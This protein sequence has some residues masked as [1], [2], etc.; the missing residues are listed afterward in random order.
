MG[1]EQVERWLAPGGVLAR[2]LPGYAPRPAQEAMARRVAEAL[3]RGGVLVCEA[4]TGTGKTLAYLLPA[5]LSGRRVV[6][7]TG[8]RTLQDQ[9]FHRELPLLRRVLAA[10]GLPLRAA[11]LKGRANYLCLHRLAL[12][13]EG[14]WASRREAG[15]WRKVRAWSRRTRTGDVAELEGIPEDAAL[16]PRVTS[17]ADNCLGQACP[18]L[19]DCFLM[20]ARQRAQEASLVVVNHHLLLAGL[21][22][23]E[24]GHGE[25]LPE[26]EA[27]VVDEAHHLPE[28][29]LRF[30]DEGLTA[31][32][33]LELARDA[34]AE[35]RR[36]AGDQEHLEAAARRLEASVAAL[37][38]A[39][40][41]PGRRE[42]WE[43][44]GPVPLRALEAVG[45][46]LEELAGELEAA[47]PRG[48]GLAHCLRR[49][50]ELLE[51]LRRLGA[52]EEGRVRWFETTA[53]GFGLHRTPLEPAEALERWRRSLGSAWVF[54]SATLS[55][56]GDFGPFCRAL[57]LEGAETAAWESPFDYRR[58][59]LLYLPEGLPEPDRAG[60]TAAMV[61][62]LLPLLRASGG[63]A[64][65]LFTSHRALREA[66]ALLEGRL[67]H[68]LL[69]QGRAPRP[70]LLERFRAAGDA[71][72]LGTASFWEGVD[73]PGQALQL[74]AIDRL[75]FASPSDPVLRARIRR[76]R[77][78][79]RDPFRE[80]QLPQAVLALR[81]GAGRLIRGPRDRGVLA[82]CDPR[83][84][85]RAYGRAF[86]D[87][88]PPMP[89]T[90]DPERAAAFLQAAR[91]EGGS[92][93]S[94][95]S[96][97]LPPARL[98]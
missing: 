74:V 60:H 62:A 14:L 82:L 48:E 35:H 17:T 54:T 86:L 90:S 40:G 63:R 36:E 3:E 72:L 19:R 33:L 21:A 39:L 11:L 24:E 76:L 25:V 87:S 78:A 79:G 65:L 29:A 58:H 23:R 1:P 30:L 73:V 4:G 85:S 15:W 70:R 9:V 28:T 75:P 53:R 84:A 89:R 95:S 91:G 42:P 96:V 41:P 8:T 22:L 50:R 94:S 51:A 52:E 57:G 59:A 64:F 45:G 67:P 34:V 61:E 26:A 43:A 77:A 13:A 92:P 93:A 69:V 80:L 16:W 98:P 32:R 38:E 18:R 10:E 37:R 55:V 56:A 7:S 47:A 88:L 27:F 2:H 71:V 5:A 68:P 20:R 97:G 6:V 83:V 44:L 46:A 81:Q 31:G 12:H 49:A 66:A